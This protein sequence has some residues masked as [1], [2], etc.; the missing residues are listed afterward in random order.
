MAHQTW[1]ALLCHGLFRSHRVESTWVRCRH[2]LLIALT[3][4]RSRS[5]V[6][7][8]DVQGLT[9]HFEKWGPNAR[10]CLELARDPSKVDMFEAFAQVAA[11]AYAS[12]P[13]L[14]SYT[15][16]TVSLCASHSPFTALPS[17]ESRTTASVTIK[18]NYLRNLVANAVVE[19]G[20]AAQVKFYTQTGRHPW[21]KLSSAYIFE[22]FVCAFESDLERITLYSRRHRRC[23]NVYTP[24]CRLGI[25]FC[26]PRMRSS[27]RGTRPYDVLMA[28]CSAQNVPSIN[29]IVFTDGLIVTIRSTIAPTHDAKNIGFILVAQAFNKAIR[30]FHSLQWRHIFITHSD[31]NA[32]QLRDSCYR[33]WSQIRFWS[34]LRS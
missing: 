3:Q 34:T 8:L 15:Q 1:S 27:P 10:I 31:E 2:R 29:A 9:Q 18:T 17:N 19:L 22:K 28:P 21:F 24:P 13:E 23:G 20:A 14:Y 33:A 7:G 16:A 11:R 6:L 30:Y 12:A 26:I 5:I 25:S 32:Q 4:S